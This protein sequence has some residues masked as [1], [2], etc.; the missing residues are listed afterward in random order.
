MLHFPNDQML[1]AANYM[2]NDGSA[3]CADALQ[4]LIDENPNRTI[5]F[6]DGEYLISKPL[7]TSGAATESTAFY[8]SDNAVIKASND[9]KGGDDALIKLGISNKDANEN[10]IFR[11]Q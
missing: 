6:P 4:K 5:Y 11:K 10:N 8:L 2:K 1:N 9:W 3:D 7:Q